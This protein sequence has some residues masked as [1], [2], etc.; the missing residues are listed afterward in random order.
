MS[1]SVFHCDLQSTFRRLPSTIF[2]FAVGQQALP[3]GPRTS[4]V[5]ATGPA[6]LQ[7]LTCLKAA[8]SLGYVWF[9]LLY[10]SHAAIWIIGSSRFLPGR[11]F[12]HRE[13]YTIQP[14]SLRFTFASRP[15]AGSFGAYQGGSAAICC[16]YR[17]GCA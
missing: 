16:I 6:A 17:M 5:L 4:C 12:N 2:C 9:V 10:D 7:K 13:P 14:T 1:E 15:G 3:P 11:M 8:T